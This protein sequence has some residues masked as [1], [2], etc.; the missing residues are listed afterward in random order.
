MLAAYNGSVEYLKEQRLV[1]GDANPMVATSRDQEV[2]H[3]PRIFRTGRADRACTAAIL[4]S[5]RGDKSGVFV[6]RLGGGH[7]LRD[8]LDARRH[9]RNKP[10]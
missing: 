1:L 5:L 6:R 9:K 7:R 10:T 4:K 8:R 2:L 3:L